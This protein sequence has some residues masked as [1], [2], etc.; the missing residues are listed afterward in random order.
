MR[1]WVYALLAWVLMVPPAGEGNA[2]RSA[3]H[4]WLDA[5]R[6]ESHGECERHK[7][8]L[9]IASA[10]QVSRGNAPRFSAAVCLALETASRR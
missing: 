6:F 10:S 9:R 3:L 1:K 4:E 5:G 2:S 7:R 8:R